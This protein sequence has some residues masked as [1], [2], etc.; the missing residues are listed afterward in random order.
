MNKIIYK[1]MLVIV[2][3]VLT[4]NCFTYHLPALA[5]NNDQT[6]TIST[7]DTEVT[8]AVLNNQPVIMQIKNKIN[9]Q[10]WLKAPSVITLINHIKI[11]Q[12]DITLDWKYVSAKVENNGNKVTFVF[13]NDSPSLELQSVWTAA[14]DTGALRHSM[15]IQNNTDQDIIIY[16][17]PT[18]SF[19]ADAQNNLTLR[20]I[21]KDGNT[22]D[23]KGIYDYKINNNFKNDITFTPGNV[24]SGYIP[25]AMLQSNNQHGIFVG[26]EWPDGDILVN[27]SNNVTSVKI[28]MHNNFKTVLPK[29][30]SF[31]FPTSFIGTY[32]GD[33]DDGS[34]VLKNWLFQNNMPD[35]NRSNPDTPFVEINAFYYE[36]IQKAN[37]VSCEDNFLKPLQELHNLGVQEVTTDIGW[38]PAL[39]DWRGDSV[40]WPSGM[41]AI[42]QAVKNAG[43]RFGMYYTF[44]NGMSTDPDALTS[45][46]P[47]GHPDWF[48][49]DKKEAG[50][51]LGNADAV[52]WIKNRLLQCLNNYGASTFRS[53]FYPILTTTTRINR[54]H[55]S[56]IDTAYWSAT[57]FYDI[58]DY[59]IANKADFRYEACNWGGNYKDYATSK[60]ASTIF[61]TDTYT[62]LDCRKSFYD[63]SYAFPSIQLSTPLMD[64]TPQNYPGWHNYRYRS[65]MLGAWYAHP[66]TPLEMSD[67]EL[68]SIRNS[69]SIYKSWVKPLVRDCADLYHIL[70]RPDGKNWDGV[71]YFDTKTGKG[72]AFIFK[73][74]DKVANTKNIKLKGLNPSDSYTIWTEDGSSARKTTTGKELMEQGI[75]L[76]LVGN[77][78]SDLIYIKKYDQTTS[79]SQVSGISQVASSSQAVANS[80]TTT[81]S[82]ISAGSQTVIAVSTPVSGTSAGTDIGLLT[83]SAGSGSNPNTGEAGI[84]ALIVAAAVS[85]AAVIMIKCNK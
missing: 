37:W 74:S 33:F 13:K 78:M 14:S 17:Q 68:S 65:A 6:W 18:L 71:Q 43:M 34:N 59:L 4:L 67:N 82:Q 8:L 10:N 40:R 62:A 50:V 22:P 38:W 52:N 61:L 55:Y 44:Q 70:P 66:D 73:P 72:I 60:R 12:Q 29:G 51:D 15:S 28:G 79:S 63:S 27:N 11:S 26:F 23:A 2:C 58:L 85:S 56:G 75:N 48:Q 54:G 76:T 31:Q 30:N 19:S 24:G 81:S 46:G 83:T 20:A 3:A 57:G 49:N 45:V 9:S 39:G 64:N 5:D 16:N 53:D 41:A 36:G 25:L 47:N 42:G 7:K 77:Y 35:V 84:L 69:I 1:T 32:T 80:Q 21:N